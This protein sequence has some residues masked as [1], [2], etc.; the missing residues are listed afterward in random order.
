[1]R[2]CVFRSSGV[3]YC[4]HKYHFLD[5]TGSRQLL[6]LKFKYQ[7]IWNTL[8]VKN[9]DRLHKDDYFAENHVEKS[10]PFKKLLQ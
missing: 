2:E 7:E 3:E 10:P 8:N 1:M 4:T 9:N 5:H 6:F